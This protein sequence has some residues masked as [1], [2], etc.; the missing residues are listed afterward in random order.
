MNESTSVPLECTLRHVYLTAMRFAMIMCAMK[1]LDTEDKQRWPKI[2]SL[3][4]S[5]L[6]RSLYGSSLAQPDS[7]SR[8][9]WL[10]GHRYARELT[11]H[12]TGHICH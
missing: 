1:F 10:R 11:G 6:C 3:G 5:R 9:V 12:I 2:G 4:M 8:L 7:L